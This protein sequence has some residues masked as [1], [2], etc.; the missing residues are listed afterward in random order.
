MPCGPEVGLDSSD[1]GSDGT[2]EG[3]GFAVDRFG[4][5]SASVSALFVLFFAVVS[6]SMDSSGVGVVFRVLFSLVEAVEDF[7]VEAESFGGSGSNG[8]SEGLAFDEDRLGVGSASVFALFVLFFGVDSGSVDSSGG[9]V[10][11]RAPF[12]LVEA[13]E[14]FGVEAES[15]G[16]ENPPGLFLVSSPTAIRA[17][18]RK[19]RNAGARRIM[20]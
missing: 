10:V 4:V 5:G 12:L 20:E 13:V 17:K 19:R 18:M 14:D 1:S 7:D 6:G 11:F 3:L 15:F 8:T 9:G 2:G 16:G